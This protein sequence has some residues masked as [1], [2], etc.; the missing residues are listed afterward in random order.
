MMEF[1][2]LFKHRI[3]K[4]IQ[5]LGNYS[6][7]QQKFWRTNI[8]CLRSNLPYFRYFLYHFISHTK[9]AV[10]CEEKHAKLR[11]NFFFAVSLCLFSSVSLRFAL[12]QSE[13]CSFCIVYIQYIKEVVNVCI[14]EAVSRDF[15]LFFLNK[16]MVLRILF[17]FREDICKK[18]A[19]A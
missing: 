6:S 7:S 9:Y 8:L 10:R 19:S 12:K 17:G 4:A 16:K 5:I 3:Y 11:L 13:A 2:R 1:F 15:Q 18:R 14:K